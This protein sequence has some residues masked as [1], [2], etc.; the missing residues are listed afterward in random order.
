MRSGLGEIKDENE[1]YNLGIFND[2][3]LEGEVIRKNPD[4]KKSRVFYEEDE[5]NDESSEAISS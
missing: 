2:G 1:N 3:H 4:G 5:Q